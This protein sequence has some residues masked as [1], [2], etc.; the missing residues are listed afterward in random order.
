[1]L[2]PKD[3][4]ILLSEGESAEVEFKT[5]L[6]ADQVLASLFVAF[7]NSNGGVLL[8]GVDPA[9]HAIG[10]TK[11]EE[12][13]A[14]RRLGGLASELIPYP[15]SIGSIGVDYRNLV[16]VEVPAA[17]AHLKPVATARGETFIRD[18]ASTQMAR[19]AHE[20]KSPTPAGGAPCAV[21][22]A[23]S[24]RDEEEPHLVD[25]FDAMEAAARETQL[26]FTVKKIDLKPGDYE[27]SQEI[28]RDIDTADI[29]LADFTLSAP[30]VYFELGYARGRGKVV[31]Q[32]ARQGTVLE[33]DVRNWRTTFYKNAR[34]LKT[35]LTPEFIEAYKRV[36][37]G[38]AD[39]K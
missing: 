32:T 37:E 1:M 21:F 23:M 10:L 14:L 34:E 27:I 30:N 38:R 6:P 2:T 28:M 26:P 19:L 39:Q 18:G 3:V 9:G 22:V 12:E 8:I 13:R 33:F 36:V 24:F 16:Y 17:P 4:A 7:A 5:N 29:I 25:Y 11:P 35:K 15:V 20:T 31:V